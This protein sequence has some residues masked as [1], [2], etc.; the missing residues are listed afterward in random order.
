MKRKQQFGN[1]STDKIKQNQQRV[2][3]QL[4][5]PAL[6]IKCT[7]KTIMQILALLLCTNSSTHKHYL[8]YRT[9]AAATSF[10]KS[11]CIITECNHCIDFNTKYKTSF[12]S[13]IQ[14]FKT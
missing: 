12:F 8:L 3:D 9:N 11:S 6:E 2:R 7:H 13:L 10:S 5:S 14:K 4:T 1:A